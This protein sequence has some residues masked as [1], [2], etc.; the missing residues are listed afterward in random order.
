VFTLE[1]RKVE[2]F[3]SVS[4]AEPLS[5]T[6]SPDGRWVAYASTERAGGLL[7]P[8]R[9]VFVEPFPA[10]GERH[11]APKRGLDFHPVWSPD[12]NAI[13]Y[14]AV[15]GSNAQPLVSVPV[16]TRP[17]LD[18]GTP[19][20]LTRVSAPYVLSI[21]TRAYDALPDGRFFSV[22]SEPDA[23]GAD[24]AA[25]EIRVVVNWTEELKRLVPGR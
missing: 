15:G 25:N 23:A 19:V 2:R 20:T 16:R 3:G 14:V 7:S 24:G 17:A 5:A 4:S 6:F 9:G 10:T 22:V 12:G 1:G 18:F 13:L 11:Q 21:D 8:D